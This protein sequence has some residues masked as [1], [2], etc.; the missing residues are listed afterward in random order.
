MQPD[1]KTT[2]RAVRVWRKNHDRPM[3]DMP[4]D[5]HQNIVKLLDARSTGQVT[6]TKSR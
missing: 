2:A 4:E 1:L 5:L 3:A 6:E